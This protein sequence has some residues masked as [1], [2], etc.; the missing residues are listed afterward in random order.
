MFRVSG[1]NKNYG[2]NVYLKKININYTSTK[3]YVV[4]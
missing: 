3:I 4:R 1:Y 2:M